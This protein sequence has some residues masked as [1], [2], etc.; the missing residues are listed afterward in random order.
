MVVPVEILKKRRDIAKDLIKVRDM[1]YLEFP[2]SN[3]S[4]IETAVSELNN[5]NY[6][7][8]IEAKASDSNRWGYDAHE[9]LFRFPTS[10]RKSKP[11]PLENTELYLTVVIRGNATYLE[12]YNDPLEALTFDIVIKGECN[13]EK[14]IC[15]YH[16]D[17][18]IYKEGDKKPLESH[19]WYHFQF[20]GN[21]LIDQYGDL[22]TGGVLFLDSPR[23]PHHPM[24]LI[25]GIDFLLSNFFPLS[26]KNLTENKPEYNNLIE[27]YQ[28]LILKPYI[29]N[30][31]SQWGKAILNGES[32]NWTPIDIFPQFKS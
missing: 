2:T 23:I 10:P 3:F 17:R 27:K 26:W 18:H 22:N 11:Y 21:K 30:F 5:N 28:K 25:L 12:T 31:A 14:H 1:L 16:L 20:G 8:Q 7:P 19:P 32:V 4:A 9:L 15:T 24:D 13:N 6:I 29:I